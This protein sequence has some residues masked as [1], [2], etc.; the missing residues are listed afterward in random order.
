M[1]P[2]QVGFETNAPASIVGM[3]TILKSMFKEGA[4]PVEIETFLNMIE[5]AAMIEIDWLHE[6]NRL[7]QVPAISYSEFSW[8]EKK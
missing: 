5:D 7:G 1:T 6:L 4:D 8:R 3:V 2:D